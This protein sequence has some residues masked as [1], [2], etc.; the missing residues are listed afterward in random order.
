MATMTKQRGTISQKVKRTSTEGNS[1]KNTYSIGKISY[2]TP[3]F[4]LGKKPLPQ[5]KGRELVVDPFNLQ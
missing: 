3:I 2:D 4:N 1:L 5:I